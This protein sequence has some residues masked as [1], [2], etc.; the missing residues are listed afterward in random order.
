MNWHSGSIA[1]AVSEAK[2]TNKL[3][4]VFIEGNDDMSKAM[5]STFDDPSISE[6]LAPE[7]V[8]ALKLTA[9]SVPYMQFCQI[10]PVLVIPSSFFIG[11]NGTPIEIITGHL[12]PADFSAKIDKIFEVYEKSYSTKK[13]DSLN[14]ASTSSSQPEVPLPTATSSSTDVA[15]IPSTSE[16]ATSSEST[17]S[18]ED[19]VERAKVLLE[20]K[21]QA[22]SLEEQEK[23]KNDEIARRN[24]G[25]AMQ[26]AQLSKKEA[27]MKEWAK[28]RAKEK[29]EE[30]LAR[31]KVKAMIA[32]D[33]AEQAARYQRVKEA[34]DAER[35]RL[36]QLREDEERARR[37]SALHS[38]EARLQF[39]LPDGSFST[40]CF[41]AEATLEEARTYV[42]QEVRPPF[43]NFSLCTTFPRRHFTEPDY[44]ETL[45]DLEL[46][47]SAVLLILP[48]Q[49]VSNP[50]RSSNFLLDMFWFALSPITSI[51][52]YIRSFFVSDSRPPQSTAP[53]SSQS[54]EKSQSATSEDSKQESDNRQSAVRRRESPFAKREGNIFRINNQSDDDENNTWNGNSTQQ[55]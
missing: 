46:A 24:M 39:R 1:E 45:R 32:Q 43:S 8:I 16:S 22:K 47:P 25:K 54:P 14:E 40:H 44:S 20:A 15:Q 3:F 9:N 42:R 18:L 53:R 26:Q 35:R 27:E 34:E 21:R 13:K 48:E 31:E 29:E 23:E 19:K 50:S 52:N 17:P 4:L 36:Q 28:N 51:W 6:K 37:Q 33:R 41:P 55:M 38:N 11:G 30:R 5:N 2:R 7:K 49:A 12:L 10:Y